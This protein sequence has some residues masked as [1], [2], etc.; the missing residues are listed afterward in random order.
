[1]ETLAM[2]A[3]MNTVVAYSGMVQVGDESDE[4][5]TYSY[6]DELGMMASEGN[7]DIFGTVGEI[8]ES[9]EEMKTDLEVTPAA[10]VVNEEPVA[11]NEIH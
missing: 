7:T 4:E 11:I 6:M 10:L 8:N 3:K 2:G 9:T 1:M 5:E